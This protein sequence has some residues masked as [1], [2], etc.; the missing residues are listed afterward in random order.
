MMMIGSTIAGYRVDR[1][2]G[3]GGMA[4]VYQ[5]YDERLNRKVALK[6]LSPELA[7][8]AAFRARF[9]RESRAAAAVD[10]RNIIPVYD[11]GEW[12]GVLYIAMRYLPGGDVRTLLERH[13]CLPPARAHH[14]IAEVAA[15][16]DAAHARGLIH[17][18]VKPGNMLLEEGEPA[19]SA[20][21]GSPGGPAE[22]DHVCLSDFGISKHAVSTGLTLTGQF[23]GTLDYIAPE[24]IEG[25]EVDGRT[26]QYSLACTA[27]ELLTGSPPFGRTQPIAVMSAQLSE[28]VPALSARRPGL[29]AAAD[30][31]LARALA[32]NPAQ[33][34]A[35][36]TQ[37]A[38]DLGRALGVGLPEPGPPGAVQYPA[39]AQ[40][41]GAGSYPGQDQA[42]P[43]HYE[44][45]QAAFAA[46][47][48]PPAVPGSQPGWA[49]PTYPGYQGQP[50]PARPRRR[51]AVA[52]WAAVVLVAVG[53]ALAVAVVLARHR[54]P[55]GS[56]AVAGGPASS[57]PAV[58]A[59]PVSVAQRQAAAVNA[60]LGRM[61][62]SRS[63][64]QNAISQIQ[65]CANV[66][67]AESTIQSVTSQRSAEYQQAQSLPTSALAD[68][69]ALK[70]DLVQALSGSL[71]ADQS[72]LAWSQQE[73]S[74]CA[75]GSGSQSAD[76][77]AAVTQS[78]Q[79]NPVKQQLVGVWNPTAARYG[80]PQRQPGGI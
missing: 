64:L 48:P 76:Y 60:L 78:E 71:S 3:R 26:D 35:T 1:E 56:A 41:S 5:A 70:S 20:V 50:P 65:G 24:Q 30:R 52:A 55:A 12:S 33:R 15:A 80:Y 63:P 68:G 75:P 57:V 61:A 53:A 27:F 45:T 28:P 39:A 54:T 46:A 7:G 36:C 59:S 79:V 22:G 38:A 34:Y 77:G 31:V 69:A 44:P 29:P 32:K 18:D 58:A 17:R 43:G 6:V 66:A 2:I 42:A 67:S 19:D 37:F 74:S 21:P 25:R 47:G 72:Y 8:D 9:I 73:L 4:T 16:L 13:G 40:Y 62:V 51:G 23:V 14:I 11:A 10:H 49:R